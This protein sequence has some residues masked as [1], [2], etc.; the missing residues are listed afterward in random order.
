MKQQRTIYLTIN[1]EELIKKLKIKILP[2]KYELISMSNS[3]DDKSTAF[4]FGIC[5]EVEI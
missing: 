4:R 1:E 3:R 5:Y 2:K